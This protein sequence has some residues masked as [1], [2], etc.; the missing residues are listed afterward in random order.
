ML[1]QRAKTQSERF[2]TS[3]R[4]QEESINKLAS[5]LKQESHERHFAD[6]E[7]KGKAVFQKKFI[8]NRMSELRVQAN[9]RLEERR[10]NLAML[11]RNEQEDFKIEIA[12]L[13]ETPEQVR[14][15]MLRRV[16]ELKQRKEASRKVFVEEQLEKKFENEADELRKVDA[17]FKEL[18]TVH[19]RNI[20]M[21]EKQK[22]MEEQFRE[23]M[24][25]ADLYK[26]DIKHKEK[27]EQE[28]LKQQKKKVEDRNMILALQKMSQEEREK[29]EIELDNI[30][31][32]MLVKNFLSYFFSLLLNFFVNF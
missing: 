14:D 3:R 18:K 16:H 17:D 32:Q 9:E 20:Q 2:I 6:W 15:R 7:I 29:K 5:K 23:E 31:K 24:I 26:R 19:Q 27:V 25:Y 4:A 10:E 22:A 30:E 12:G 13:E 21:M 11:L 8:N 28:V 1:L